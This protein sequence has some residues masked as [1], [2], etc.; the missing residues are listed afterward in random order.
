MASLWRASSQGP[1]AKTD[2]FVLLGAGPMAIEEPGCRAS[3]EHQHDSFARCE[4]V[5]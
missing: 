2:I 1:P 4:E 3:L 5:F